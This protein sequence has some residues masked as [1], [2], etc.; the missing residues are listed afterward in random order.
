MSMI[1]QHWILNGN[2]RML[3]VQHRP[4]GVYPAAVAV[5]FAGFSH[6]M[7]DVD[8]FM[9]RLARQLVE[10]G[11]LVAQ[12][13]P[14]GHGD[15]P[16]D[17]SDVDLDTLRADIAAALDHYARTYSKNIVCIGRGLSAS[18]L[19]ELSSDAVLGV[20]GIGP[21]AL[22]GALVRTHLATLDRV[23][24]DAFDMFPG[25]NYSDLSD[26]SPAA[27]RII[28]ALG[29][30]AYNLHGLRLSERLLGG[31]AGYD[32][33]AV[34][35]PPPMPAHLWLG[36]DDGATATFAGLSRGEVPDPTVYDQ[37]SLPRDPAVQNRMIARLAEWAQ[38]RALSS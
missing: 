7:C 6:A 1:H 20:A 33:Q 23:E 35:G 5:L 24:G 31:L 19:A 26:F 38:E 27:A 25:N 30:L 2:I 28:H 14:R 18:L 11:F 34:L 29:A 3:A 16:G 10:L 4:T 32:A 36:H 12:V 9:S 17:F 22:E 13:D 21:Y 37:P 8:Y 15:S